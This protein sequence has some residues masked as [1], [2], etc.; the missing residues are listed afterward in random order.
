MQCRPPL[1]RPSS[2]RSGREPECAAVTNSL[3]S[4]RPVRRRRRLPLHSRKRKKNFPAS[5]SFSSEKQCRTFEY[6]FFADKNEKKISSSRVERKCREIIQSRSDEPRP[7]P[8]AMHPPPLTTHADQLASFRCQT[9]QQQ[10][11]QNERESDT[12]KGKIPKIRSGSLSTTQA[13]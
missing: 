1:S 8:P 11:Q 6:V 13:L 12:A 7:I 2:S 4:W 3:N 5:F 10:Q 9:Q